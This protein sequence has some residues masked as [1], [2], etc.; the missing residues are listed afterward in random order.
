MDKIALTGAQKSRLRGLGQR[1]E[2][3]IKIGKEGVTPTI[4]GELRRQLG[5]HELVKLRFLGSPRDERATLCIKLSEES[6]GIFVGSVG[7]T[8]LFFTPT[9]KGPADSLLEETDS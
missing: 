8:A 7:Q 4:V 6:G 5:A 1:I 9:S 2:A 3:S